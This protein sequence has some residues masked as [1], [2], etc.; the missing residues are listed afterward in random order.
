M[1]HTG[2]SISCVACATIFRTFFNRQSDAVHAD[3]VFFPDQLQ[4]H[5]CVHLRAVVN[6]VKEKH[7]HQLLVQ[8]LL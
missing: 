2:P 5:P 1:W 7:P 6:A 3:V 4:S 8:R